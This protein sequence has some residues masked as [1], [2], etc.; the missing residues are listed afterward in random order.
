LQENHVLVNSDS[1]GMSFIATVF[2][3][4]AVRGQAVLVVYTQASMQPSWPPETLVASAD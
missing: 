4:S 1:L 2:T 3:A